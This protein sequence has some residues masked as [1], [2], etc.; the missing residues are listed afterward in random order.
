VSGESANGWNELI[1]EGGFTEAGICAAQTAGVTVRVFPQRENQFHA[2]ARGLQRSD[3][4][5]RIHAA[6]I[7]DDQ[8]WKDAFCVVHEPGRIGHRANHV[9]FLKGRQQVEDD[10]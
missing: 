3:C 8:V 4:F 2:G 5:R 7:G 6:G 10:P 1:D 9:H